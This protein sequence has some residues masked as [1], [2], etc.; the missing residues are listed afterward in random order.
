MVDFHNREIISGTQEQNLTNVHY[1]S[2]RQ[3]EIF[4]K[5]VAR[6]SHSL[7]LEID[8]SFLQSAKKNLPFQARKLSIEL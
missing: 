1:S 5:T 2:T 6:A 8:D 4:M 7:H 3:L